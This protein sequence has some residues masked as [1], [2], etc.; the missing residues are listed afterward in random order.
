MSIEDGAKLIVK[1][2]EEGVNI[3]DTAELYDTY[4]FVKEALKYI[5]REKYFIVAKSYA[6]DR[7]TAQNSL[8][9]ALN[10]MGI[11][12]VDAFLLH[13]QEGEYTLKGHQEAIDYFL[14][15]K[16]IGTIRNF[17]ISTHYVAGVLACAKRDDIDI[18][19]PLV[20][21]DSIGIQDGTVDDMIAAINKAKE[22]NIGIYSMKALGGGNLISK[23]HEALDFVLK[24][25]CVDSIA[26]GMQSVEEIKAN[27]SML[28][29]GM[30]PEALKVNLSKKNR[31]LIIDSWCIG[32]GNCQAKCSYGA[33]KVVNGKAQVE[34]SKCLV[35][36]YCA[37]YCPE[38]C[39]K[40]I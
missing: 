15:Q 6:Y 32:C 33:I 3:I 40:V 39:I 27:T 4:K 38:F 13:E 24:L 19:H 14:E 16:T 20:N 2:Y 1:A 23:Y 5:P 26:I 28:E 8:N 35:C 21:I 37:G 34:H 30:I 10:N 29:S 9:K 18:I 12:Y 11:K 31:K 22:K 36:S 7:Q 17:G 25:D